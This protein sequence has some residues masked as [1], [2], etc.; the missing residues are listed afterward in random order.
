VAAL[1]IVDDR[2][3]VVVGA[4]ATAGATLA[5]ADAPIAAV[6]VHGTPHTMIDYQYRSPT[7]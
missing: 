2:A 5:P 6:P 7:R 4:P 3:A 1:L